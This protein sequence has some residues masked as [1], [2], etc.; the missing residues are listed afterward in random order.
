MD[1]RLAVVLS[2]IGVYLIYRTFRQTQDQAE[3]MVLSVREAGRAASAMEG[4]ADSMA[5]N[6]AQVVESVRHQRVFGKMQM[7]AH[8]SV[9]IGGGVYQD[10]NLRFEARPQIINSGHTAARK[11]RWRISAG[12]LPRD[13]LGDFRFPI[14]P[15]V[16]G[17]SDLAPHQDGFM[18][19]VVPKR[20][21]KDEVA[22]IKAG[23]SEAFCVW[24]AL[25]YEDVFGKTHRCTFA[26][27]LWWQATGENHPDGTPR[28]IVRGI[29]LPKHN[30]SN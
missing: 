9:V 10:E 7:R 19:V 16:G 23:G 17:G 24:G 22:K 18:S 26:Q 3:D 15:E 8:V 11:V 13:T 12:I 1:V 21:E 14:P 20:V 4:V 27:L 28:E 6:A 2:A 5:I 29:Y 30:R 25:S